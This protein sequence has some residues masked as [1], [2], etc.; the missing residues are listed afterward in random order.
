MT[1]MED[2]MA[3][4]GSFRKHTSKKIFVVIHQTELEITVNTD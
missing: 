3:A 1:M 2:G 4:N